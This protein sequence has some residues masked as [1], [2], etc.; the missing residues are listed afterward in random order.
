[1]KRAVVLLIAILM[2]TSAVL[3][4]CNGEKDDIPAGTSEN[5]EI[6]TEPEEITTEAEEEEDYT[7]QWGN[8]EDAELIGTWITANHYPDYTFPGY[9]E[10]YTF[11]E[12][13]TCTIAYVTEEYTLKDYLDS[14]NYSIDGDSLKIYERYNEQNARLSGKY[15]INGKTLT[16]E[17]YGSSKTWTMRKF[18]GSFDQE[19]KIKLTK[20]YVGTYIE[21][22]IYRG[23]VDEFEEEFLKNIDEYPIEI[24]TD[25]YKT[26]SAG[27]SYGAKVIAVYPYDGKLSRETIRLIWVPDLW[28]WCRLGFAIEREFLE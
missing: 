15:A 3:C 25:Y 5:E 28:C 23:Y 19:P 14:F 27:I 9:L 6:T 10:L 2:V 11:Y 21:N 16:L 18:S 20:K 24:E 12:D 7:P 4:S 22:D 26:R 8:E 1:M 17:E 13:G